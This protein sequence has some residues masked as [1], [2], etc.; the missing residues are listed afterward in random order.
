MVSGSRINQFN[1][2]FDRKISQQNTIFQLR[3]ILKAV[4]PTLIQQ[5]T[6]E[7]SHSTS[8]RMT[9]GLFK[10]RLKYLHY[11]SIL[12]VPLTLPLL[13]IICI[14]INAKHNEKSFPYTD[15]YIQSIFDTVRLPQYIRVRYVS[16][17]DTVPSF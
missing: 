11:D 10:Y 16:R 14:I 7:R 17:H 2:A 5:I 12:S 13:S 8:N 3:R 15:R 4:R 1:F 6:T 9:R